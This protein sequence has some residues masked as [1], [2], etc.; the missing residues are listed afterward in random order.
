MAK[1]V[2]REHNLPTRRLTREAILTRPAT[3]VLKLKTGA[4][5]FGGGG[6][7]FGPPT[8]LGGGENCLPRRSNGLTYRKTA[9]WE[10]TVGILW[11]TTGRSRPV[12]C[13]ETDPVVGRSGKTR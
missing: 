13:E 8:P 3:V 10:K 1:G 5:Q 12:A 4:A 9:S 2:R 11:K 7:G 6:I